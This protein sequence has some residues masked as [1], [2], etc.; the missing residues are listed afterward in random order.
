MTYELITGYV[1]A[2]STTLTDLTM[3]STDSLRIR[4]FDPGKKAFLQALWTLNQ[5]AGEI[6]VKSPKM[7]DAVQNIKLQCPANYNFPM[8]PVDNP[9]QVYSDDLLTVQLSGSATAGDVEIACLLMAYEDMPASQGRY[10]DTAEVKSR[11]KN[12]LTIKCDLGT[13]TSAG[14]Q[15]AQSIVADND[16]LKAGTDYA[17]LGATSNLEV[18]AICLRGAD[19]GNLRIGLPTDSTF[20]PECS[21][22]FAWLSEQTGQKTIPVMN[23][24][25]KNNTYIEVVK[26]ETSQAVIL[27]VTLAELG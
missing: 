26:N 9:T 2:P 21:N 4:H 10:I 5:G 19:T 17:I 23:S 18:G 22:W 6:V 14:Y 7:H 20:F 11:M 1:T 12:L 16:L 8:L 15:G 27:Y 24:E 3:N 13:L 25:N